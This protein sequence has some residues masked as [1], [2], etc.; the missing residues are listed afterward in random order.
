MKAEIVIAMQDNVYKRRKLVALAA[1]SAAVLLIAI[2]LAAMVAG[3]VFSQAYAFH[4]SRFDPPLAAADFT[5][6]NQDGQAIRL[7]DY[8]GKFV[9]LYFGYT[10]CP[11][12]CP[13]T[14]AMLN[15]ALSEMKDASSSTQVLFVSVDPE[16]DTPPVL[17][18]YLARFNPD[19]V[20][21]I[22]QPAEVEAVLKAY[23]VVAEKESATVTHSTYIYVIDPAGRLALT[24]SFET[25]PPPEEVAAD[26]EH[27]SAQ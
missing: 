19:F 21:L 6:T 14:L 16:Q 27:L 26:L 25:Q 11:D 22:G 20:G 10:H 24:Y 8:R 9:L 3:P 17:K 13:T 4:G 5:L 1:L 12:E 23:G 18:E 2:G 7:S 15:R